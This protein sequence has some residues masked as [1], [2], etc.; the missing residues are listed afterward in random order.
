MN[1]NTFIDTFR[2]ELRDCIL[3][4]C[5]NCTLNDEE[6]ENWILN[7]EA[8]HNWALSYGVNL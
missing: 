6:I 2:E 1:I 8:L 5:S 3:A 7:D 4:V